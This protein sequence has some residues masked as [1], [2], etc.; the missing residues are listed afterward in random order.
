MP[1]NGFA[2]Q[3][4]GIKSAVSCNGIFFAFPLFRDKSLNKGGHPQAGFHLL[5]PF[6]LKYG[7]GMGTAAFILLY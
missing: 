3:M 2:A 1:W 7:P 5:T 4:S 6:Q